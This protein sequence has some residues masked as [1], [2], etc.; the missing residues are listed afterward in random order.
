MSASWKISASDP[1]L[2]IL[3]ALGPEFAADADEPPDEPTR[4]RF[5]Q[6][7]GASVA[8]AGAGGCLNQPQEQIVPYVRAP[9]QIIPGKPLYYATAMTHAGGSMGLLVETHMGRPVKVE[10]NPLHP[11]VPEAMPGAN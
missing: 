3:K 9:E 10:G 8:L 7:M 11:A 5:L 2:K 4:R 1:R 6:I